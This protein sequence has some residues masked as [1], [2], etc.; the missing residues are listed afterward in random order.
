MV[1]LVVDISSDKDAALIQEILKK[2]RTVEVNSFMPDI[3]KQQVQKRI[4]AALRE[5]N[6]N[7][8][9]PWVDVKKNCNEKLKLPNSA[10]QLRIN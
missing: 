7:K 1:Q 9:T 4:D 8:T 3:S 5:S 2:F 6:E 10:L